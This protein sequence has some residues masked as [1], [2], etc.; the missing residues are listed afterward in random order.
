MGK[1]KGWLGAGVCFGSKGIILRG[2]SA[3]DE[4]EEG[5]GE[6]WLGAGVCFGSKGIIL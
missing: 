3:T 1:G 6:G 5:L 4:L 2:S